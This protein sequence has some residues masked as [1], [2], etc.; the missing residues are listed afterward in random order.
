[1]R[2]MIHTMSK[3]QTFLGILE[4]PFKKGVDHETGLIGTVVKGS[5]LEGVISGKVTVDGNDST[6]EIIRMVMSSRHRP[7]IKVIFLKG[8]S[9]AGFNVIDIQ[10]LWESTNIPVIVCIMT[11]PE[12]NKIEQALIKIG[13][14]EKI[15]I[16]QRTQGIFTYVFDSNTN[17]NTNDASKT[18]YLQCA[19]LDMERAKFYIQTTCTKSQFPESI[20]IAKIITHGLNPHMTT[21][22][23]HTKVKQSNPEKELWDIIENYNSINSPKRAEILSG[24]DDVLIIADWIAKENKVLQPHIERLINITSLNH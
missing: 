10:R 7:L 8:L 11:C 15:K 23:I 4:V 1:M 18:I 14:P 13:Q 16:Y 12:V 6:D 21:K 3:I 20:R 5:D 19:G 24:S 22:P 17:T 9:V 2:S